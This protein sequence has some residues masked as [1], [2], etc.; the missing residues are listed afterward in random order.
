MSETVVP[1]ASEIAA[2]QMGKKVIRVVTL[3][4]VSIASVVGVRLLLSL[5]TRLPLIPPYLYSFDD[6]NLALALTRFDPSR[7]QPQPPGYPFFVG[8]E[9]LLHHFIGSPEHTFFILEVVISGLSVAMLYLLGRRMFSKNVGAFAAVLLFVNPVFWFSALT[10]PLRPHLALFS[11]LIAYLCWRVQNGEEVYFYLASIVLG[12]ASGF[13]PELLPLLFP[14]W[15]WTGWKCRGRFLKLMRGTFFAGVCTLIWVTILIKYSGG[16]ARMIPLFTD[17][18]FTQTAQTSVVLDPRSSTWL[19]WAG[20]A[21]IWNF[22]GV[23]PWIWLVPFGWMQ[24]RMI[25]ESKR[26]FEFLAVWFVPIFAF[27]LAVHIGDP[28]HALLSIPVICLVGGFC[29]V[30][31]GQVV[32]DRW[33]PDFKEGRAIIII[34][35]LSASALLFYG[36]FPVPQRGR[37]VSGFRGLQSLEDSVL[38]G[39]YETS[40]ARVRWV[41]EMME[42]A[43]Q[44]IRDLE[45]GNNR[46][47]LLLWARDGEP[48]WRKVCFYRPDEKVY[49]LDEAGDPAVPV[50]KAQYLTG[51][52]RLATYMGAPPIR[53]PI[54][55]GGRLIWIIAPAAVDSLRQ[56]IPVETAPPL[57]YTDL[58]PDAPPF[59]WGSFEFSPQ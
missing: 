4:V 18:F 11:I 29:V 19:R 2:D 16:F 45:A 25:P 22:L 42:L 9:R 32:V 33:F 48:V 54:P 30:S 52:A 10:S 43:M 40:Y 27:H 36:Q 8:E 38:I 15:A 14:L 17:Y 31:A 24:R 12:L 6:I 7:N 46:P 13:R 51:S 59:R 21:I 44:R 20:R 49:S 39:T 1:R 26:V 53:I 5:L 3:A 55:K 47:V 56:V 34:I 23:L 28:D 37:A 58:P 41:N 57:Y 50:G 35:V